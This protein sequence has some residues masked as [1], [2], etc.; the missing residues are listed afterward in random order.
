MRVFFSMSPQNKTMK[1]E[2]FG[3]L[4]TRL[5]TIKTSKNVCS[6]GP[7][8]IYI[9][10][11]INTIDPCTSKSVSIFFDGLDLKRT[12]IFSVGIFFHQKN[13]RDRCSM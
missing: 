9:S 6:G 7:W 4:K 1:N 13:P 10:I 2:G 5:F 3:H 12:I 8:Y 11:F